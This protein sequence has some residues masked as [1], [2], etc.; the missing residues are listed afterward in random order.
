M[1]KVSFDRIQYFASRTLLYYDIFNYPLKS[2]EVYR[3]LGT[4]STT[5]QDVTTAL[6]ELAHS[7]RIYRFGEFY[8]VQ[9]N[10]ANVVRRLKGNAEATKYLVLAK[11]KAAFIAGFPFVRGVFASGSLSKNYM[12]EKSDLDFFVVTAP[13]R[14]WIART[15]LVMY[16]R[17]FLLNSHKY[18]CV[19]Y[20]VDEKHLEIEEK[21]LFTATELATI[22]PLCG[23]EHYPNLLHANGWLK[24]I[25]P[26]FLP[27]TLE[28][29]P[30]GN[31]TGV[32]KIL[33]AV[34]NFCFAGRLERYFKNLTLERWKKL[35][36]KD[37]PAAD[38]QIAFKSKEYAS[39]NHPKN[40]QQKVM[41][42]YAGKLSSFGIA[43]TYQKEETLKIGFEY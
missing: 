23:A 9:P 8:S 43:A 19:N 37:Y 11:K 18:F 34:I 22:I 38:F 10:E 41:D 25:F 40:Y 27:R 33:E 36:R 17:I 3:F 24:K 12:D 31:T 15:L 39:K 35:Y 6:D 26:N 14:L 7:K 32:K 20:F 28:G 30:D 1:S 13:G 5:E 21:N 29:V 2:D 16:K 4:N 42:L